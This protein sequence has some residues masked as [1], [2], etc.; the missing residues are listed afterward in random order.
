LLPIKAKSQSSYRF[1]V[2]IPLKY[3]FY[4]YF[5]GPIYEQSRSKSG[6]ARVLNSQQQASLFKAIQHHCHPEK[7]T[8]I[9]QI[10]FK[11][12][13][14]AQEIA[15]LQ[16]KEVAQFNKAGT[17]FKL[18]EVMSLPAAYTKSADAMKRSKN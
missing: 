9:M 13:L 15:L 12:G 14:R 6:Q 8:A 18:L 2:N 10:S 1:F 5:S 3:Y 4:G 16:I 17:G 7:N 11:L